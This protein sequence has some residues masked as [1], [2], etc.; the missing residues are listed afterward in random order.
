MPLPNYR[1][2][3]DITG[4]NPDNLVE[5]ELRTLNNKTVRVI[6]PSYGPFFTE[7][8]VLY[9]NDTN[10]LLNKGTDYKCVGL[11]QDATE[12]YGKEICE[13][14]LV[15]KQGM[16]SNVRYNYQVLGG[17]FQLQSEFIAKLYDA[18]MHDDR[19]IDWVNVLNKPAGYNPSLHRHLL[20]DIYGFEPVVAAIERL[21][22]AI[23]LS[24]VPA[25]ESIHDRITNFITQIDLK[26]AAMQGQIDSVNLNT[27]VSDVLNSS[28]LAALLV[29]KSNID[30]THQ[31]KTI[32]GETLYGTGD[33]TVQAGAAPDLK[34]INGQSLLGI[35]NIEITASNGTNV[36]SGAGKGAVVKRYN[37]AGVY[38]WAKPAGCTK[39][40]VYATGPGTM[41]YDNGYW[42]DTY[43][44]GAPQNGYV[45]SLGISEFTVIPD[46][47]DFTVGST[48]YADNSVSSIS[49]ETPTSF[50]VNGVTATASK[51]AASGFNAVSV[52]GSNTDYVSTIAAQLDAY[53][54]DPI[55][56]IS[57]KTVYS[58]S[59]I[60][61]YP[62]DS[63]DG[64]STL[65]G[66]SPNQ[67]RVIH[68]EIIIVEWYDATSALAEGMLNADTLNYPIGT[69][70][71]IHN[72]GDVN[73]GT[74]GAT[75]TMTLFE[76]NDIL[77]FK[78]FIGVPTNNANTWGAALVNLTPYKAQRYFPT[79][80]F[81]PV[82]CRKL[83]VHGSNWG[84]DSVS[85]VN[86]SY[87]DGLTEVLIPGTWKIVHQTNKTG[88]YADF[89]ST[90][91]YYHTYTIQRI[92]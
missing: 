54:V 16:S 33:I 76:M 26:L 87:N 19:P 82:A 27:V 23:I 34:T 7:S 43:W 41:S 53:R 8:V 78:K 75:N 57:N 65:E 81:I 17:K 25:F 60:G 47:I 71:D 28:G 73:G 39:I 9:D 86:N 80:T 44:A 14:I 46:T 40:E 5:G 24:D 11:L 12:Q 61:G 63:Y 67:H 30:H 92:A 10:T 83:D 77:T 90:E 58:G 49:S 6:A 29:G 48:V 72:F 64:N 56:S 62:T 55:A 50:T 37:R 13:V 59:N 32:N 70:L 89:S 36:I 31:L 20:E 15:F 69:L 51:S 18:V 1:Y 4:T 85:M 42:A 3:L 38:S 88:S 79:D 45:G 52:N 35:G 2:P 22:N 68:G 91:K 74:T 84:W 21:R 66:V